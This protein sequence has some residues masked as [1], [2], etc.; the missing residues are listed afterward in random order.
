MRIRPVA[1]LALSLLLVACSSLPKPGAGTAPAFPTTRPTSTIPPPPTLEPA[2][3]FVKGLSQVPTG[4]FLFI[5]LRNED[6][7][8][9]ECNCPVVEPPRKQ[10]GFSPSGEL[11]LSPNQTWDPNMRDPAS[12]LTS[13]I[14]G[15]FGYGRWNEAVYVIKALPYQT[16]PYGEATIYSVD[17]QGTV[18]VEVQGKTY[19]V[20]PGQAWAASGDVKREPPPGCHIT[21]TSQ[22]SNYGLLAQAKIRIGDPYTYR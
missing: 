12:V 6:L 22:L 3:D 15:F 1:V 13:T 16:P 19:F 7:C 21:W 18:V 14:I 10:Y 17:A 20:R 8:S 11:W 5:T 4:Q 2:T 9:S